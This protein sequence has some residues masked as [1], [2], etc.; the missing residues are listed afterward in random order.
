[1]STELSV[2][3]SEYGIED[4]KAVELIGNLPQIKEERAILEQQY[5]QVITMD[6]EDKETAKLA[7]ELRLQIQKNR[8]QGI[9]VW[10]KTAKDFFLK[11]GQFVDAIKRLE[12][13]VNERME[14][15][16]EEIEKHQERKEQLRLDE[17]EN[18]RKL[19]LEPYAEFVPFG[20]NIRN[21]SD[22]DFEKLLNGSKL[23]FEAKVESDR[24]AEEERLRLQQIE[25]LNKERREIALPYFQFWSDTDKQQNFGELCNDD[26]DSFI[27]NMKSAK[28]NFDSEQEKIRLENERLQ[29]E[30]KEKE[31]KLKARN[32]A[33]R[34]Y[35]RY[36]RDYE[37][38][39]N[40]NDVDFKKEISSLNKEAIETEKFE[41][42]ERS[43]KEIA[44]KLAKEEEQRILNE[45]KQSE[46]LAKAPIKEQLSV[47]VN[48]FSIPET[49]VDNETSNLIKAKFESYKTWALSEIE[50]L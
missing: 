48:S 41:A 42:E 22:E 20:A 36:I 5:S 29:K 32:E 12:T 23:Q 34:P 13:D 40:M 16:L 35:I 33:L 49:S 37:K 4:K 11:G 3:P 39:L 6:I 28:S 18:E 9:N 27:K 31:E 24:K 21:I 46:K 43:K 47:W 19:K 44:E 7:R 26:F 10:H 14:N 15:T 17:V 38:V 25:T 45:K 8:T 50:K 30:A 1:M 2:K